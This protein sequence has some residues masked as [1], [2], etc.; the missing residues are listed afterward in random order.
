MTL[1]RWQSDKLQSNRIG[2]AV[3]DKDLSPNPYERETLLQAIKTLLH[4]TVNDAR[5]QV[6]THCYELSSG[7]SKYLKE[8]KKELEYE[9]ATRNVMKE[10]SK[11][12][13]T[14]FDV[15]YYS[16]QVLAYD[17]VLNLIDQ[18]MEKNPSTAEF[19]GINTNA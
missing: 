14:E 7:Y 10:E 11:N 8:L 3:A 16:N 4:S 6:Y 17:N 18:Q 5:I 13:P 15:T 19:E 2:V 1:T 9:L 12:M